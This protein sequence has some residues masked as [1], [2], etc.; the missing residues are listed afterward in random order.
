[1]NENKELLEYCLQTAA[2]AWC[3]ESTKYKTIDSD[4]A[5][6]FA[7]ILYSEIIALSKEKNPY[8]DLIWIR[9]GDLQMLRE[10]VFN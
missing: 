6:E 2:Q 9:R 1:M 8:D 7:Q 4:L 10:S 5:K 3:K